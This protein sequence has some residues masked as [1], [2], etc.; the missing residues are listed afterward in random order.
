MSSQSSE[1]NYEESR[2]K[3]FNP[4]FE[5]HP[6]KFAITM[7]FKKYIE[8]Y[9]HVETGSRHHDMVECLAGRVLE[10]RGNGKKL[11]FYTVVS[12]GYTIQYLADVK[13]YNGTPDEFREINQSVHRGDI[14]GVRGFVGKSLK[15]ELS[16]YPLE[17]TILSPC[18]RMLP[19]QFY[20]I[21]ETKKRY[22]D[23]IVNKDVINIFKTRSKVIN[24]IRR[25]LNDNDFTEVDTPVL[26]TK[27]GGATAKP[28]ITRHEHLDIDMYMRIAP[29]L[30]LKQLVIGGLDR[31]YEIGKQFRNESLDAT[32][33]C[34]F[35]SLEFYMA[36]ADYNDLMCMVEELLSGI[37]M[38]TNSG[39]LLPYG[40]DDV[41]NFKTPYKRIHILNELEH[42]T[43]EKFDH[44]DFT[45]IE[46][47]SFLNDIC[48]RNNVECPEPRTI[49][50]ML[51]KLIGHFIEPMCINPT[52]LTNHPMVMS[53]LAKHDR[54]D[55]RLS[56]RF[57]LFVNGMELVN[58]YTELN[59]H[60]TQERAFTVQQVDKGMGDAE[61]PLPD[62]DYIEALRYGLPPTGGC[63]IGIDRLLMFLTNK[64]SIKDV[65][66]FPM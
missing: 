8:L 57:E 10:K 50:R 40:T 39:L 41:L 30:Y 31:V 24:E 12:D 27:F 29:E 33:Q 46:F 52:F 64:S 21:N 34:E 6:H 48:L 25:F 18:F 19:K 36:Y 2:L 1:K 11:N 51:D 45:S 32:H 54:S 17:I 26:S 13:E 16:I 44:V 58:A 15:G 23:M 62:E 61:I 65:I 56:E 22:L 60:L 47:E 66:L 49:A 35:Q 42:Q 4:S 37:L 38:M 55:P 5:T 63:G 14:I 28:F 7:T 43:G 53:P 59:C 3:S 9:G 20:G